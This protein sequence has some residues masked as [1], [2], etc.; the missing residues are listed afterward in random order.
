MSEYI[1]EKCFSLRDAI[2]FVKERLVAE[3]TE[4]LKMREFWEKHDPNRLKESMEEENWNDK[5]YLVYRNDYYDDRF[6]IFEDG[7]DIESW[8]GKNWSEWDLW[9]YG[10]IQG[11][12][13]DTLVIWEFHRNICI[14]KWPSLYRESKSFI[15]GWSR[16][17]E[18]VQFEV[19][20]SFSL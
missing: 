7:Y 16:K 9:D 12:L 19:L 14:E 8:L 13:D 10:N 17:R 18:Y 20:P 5:F 1:L 11:F 4:N 3:D 2:E 15:N 6:Y